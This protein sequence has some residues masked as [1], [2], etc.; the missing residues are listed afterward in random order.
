MGTIQFF[1]A[2]II[3]FINNFLVPLIFALA[4]AFFLFGM[5]RF[6]FV[7]GADAKAREEGRKLIL[8]S[9]IA[10]AVMIS[11]WGLVNLLRGSLPLGANR[12][13][14]IPTFNTGSTGTTGGTT[15]DPTAGPKPGTTNDPSAGTKPGT[16]N[17]LFGSDYQQI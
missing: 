7:K 12:M 17:D 6:F 5:F 11:I 8:W 14:D 9:V 15:N 3:A 10:F 2:Y 16:T 13:P 4:F 1:I